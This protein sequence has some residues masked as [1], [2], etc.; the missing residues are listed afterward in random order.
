MF[1]KSYPFVEIDFLSE[2]QFSHLGCDLLLVPE[3]WEGVEVESQM[4]D[5]EVV[6]P[7]IVL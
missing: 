1:M 3:M 5:G 6:L 2:F 7:G 4:I